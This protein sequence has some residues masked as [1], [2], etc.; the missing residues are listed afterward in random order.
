[1]HFGG[2]SFAVSG[3]VVMRAQQIG[4]DPGQSEA[5]EQ[6]SVAFEAQEE[7]A[8]HELVCG[9]RFAQQIWLPL[10][11]IRLASGPQLGP[12]P[13]AASTTGAMASGPES[14]GGGEAPSGCASVGPSDTSRAASS[15]G[16]PTSDCPSLASLS[17]GGGFVDASSIGG[18]PGV[19][20]SDTVEGLFE[21]PSQSWHSL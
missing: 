5:V 17:G 19:V 8:V 21:D 6:A 14:T 1:V 18:D 7:A 2:R 11:R 15:G 13:V 20:A 4:D 3:T 9:P 12:G 16:T 10:H